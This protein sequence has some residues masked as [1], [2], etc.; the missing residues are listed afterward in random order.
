MV[1]VRVRFWFRVGYVGKNYKKT[2]VTRSHE[3]IFRSEIFYYPAEV[4]QAKIQL[5]SCSAKRVRR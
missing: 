5:L 1:R 3:T 2:I 4:S